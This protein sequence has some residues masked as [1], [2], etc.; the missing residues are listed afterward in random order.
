MTIDY[1]YNDH[2]IAYID[3]FFYP[4]SCEYR[5]NIYNKGGKAIGDYAT[6][7]SVEIEKRFPNIFDC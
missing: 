4:S 5:G 6:K 1:W 7:D 3:C 2:N